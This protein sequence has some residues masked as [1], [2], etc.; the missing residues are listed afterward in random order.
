[1]Y[2]TRINDSYTRVSGAEYELNHVINTLRVYTPGAKFDPLVKM[3]LKSPYTSFVMRDGKDLIILKGHEHMI[4]HLTTVY[5]ESSEYALKT[6][7]GYLSEVIP[8]LP[9]KP[10]DYQVRCFIKCISEVKKIAL[11]C[12]GS[13]KSLVIALIADFFRSMGKRTLILVP[14]INL[15]TQFAS[16]IKSYN[17]TK[18]ANDMTIL[19]DGQTPDLS[20]SLL[21]STW[22][23]LVKHTD[24]LDK[25]PEWSFDC[26]INDECHRNAGEVSSTCASSLIT[27]RYR[28]GFTGTIPEDPVLAYRL[29]GLFGKATR[30]ITAKELIKRGLG[31]PIKVVTTIFYYHGSM[32]HALRDATQWN[33][34]LKLLKEYAPRNEY[35]AKMALER[36]R[37]NENTLVLFSHTEHGKELYRT[38][39]GILEPKLAITNANIVGKHSFAFQSPHHVYF[40]NGEDDSATR[41][42]TRQILEHENGAILV[43]N[44]AILSTG[45]N[46][47]KLHNLVLASPLKAYTTITQSLGRGIR[48]HDTKECFTVYDLVDNLT[49]VNLGGVFVRQYK[50]RVKT[51]YQ[52]ESYPI[53][54]TNAN[55]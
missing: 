36:M 19:G 39:M 13:G 49:P 33:A 46:I 10:Y 3:G 28:F 4:K 29:V 11:C 9:F 24:V 26:F 45:V 43:A 51:S 2:L 55:I 52:P 44:Y 27:T 16:D 47:R 1:M 6:I 25:E 53:T 30:F 38:I 20:K 5:P 8:S 37:A 17:L 18:L 40:I 41:E 7:T 34:Q 32:L 50:H 15:L 35:I 12:T 54:V 42:L 23:S 31:T 48:K 21:I 14:N 22:Q